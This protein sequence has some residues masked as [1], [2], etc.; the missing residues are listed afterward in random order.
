[1][2]RLIS[3]IVLLQ[4]TPAT[5]AGNSLTEMAIHATPVD[6]STNRHLSFPHP[7]PLPEGEGDQGAPS[8]HFSSLIE[9]WKNF[10]WT[11]EQQA[12][13][14]FEQGDF[15]QAAKLSR[16]PMRIGNAL[17]RAVEFEAAAA[18]FG[19]VN[20]PAGAFNQ[21]T[22]LILRGQYE[23]A[24]AAFDRAL[25][26]K[27]GWSMAEEN[28]AIAKARLARK[29]NP[30]TQEATEVGADKIV[31]DN[32]K[33][34]QSEQP[35]DTPQPGSTLSDQELRALWLQKSQTSPAVFLRAKFA[36]QLAT[37]DSQEAGK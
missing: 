26:T 6:E 30:E 33:S 2:V 35:D 15:E 12:Q 8:A 5:W 18:A 19:R 29:A 9:L 1:M 13:Q 20:T 10:W 22:A 31:Y 37:R 3:L 14:L 24:I 36:A 28:R 11:P 17:Y 4:I 32:K 25:A 27:P 34:K 7:D 21:G 23:A 16:D